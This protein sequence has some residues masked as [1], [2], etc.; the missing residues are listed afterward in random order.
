MQP[1][2][3]VPT[4]AFPAQ[5]ARKDFRRGFCSPGASK[6][7]SDRVYRSDS[8]LSVSVPGW[9]GSGTGLSVRVPGWYDLAPGLSQP[10]PGWYN[11]APALSRPVPGW[12]NSN[13]GLPGPV[14]PLQRTVR[15]PP[16]SQPHPTTSGATMEAGAP[17]KQD[18]G[19]LR[20][21]PDAPGT[22]ASNPGTWT[23]GRRSATV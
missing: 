13:P 4:R 16:H 15:A 21:R 18:F 17:V 10:V 19:S 6:T 3:A 22:F 11:L 12:Y 2:G 14:R 5:G 23:R 7:T 20:A 1:P 8:G 9:Y